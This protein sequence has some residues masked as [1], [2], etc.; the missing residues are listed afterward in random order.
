MVTFAQAWEMDR[1]TAPAWEQVVDWQPDAL[2]AY[3]DALG[4]IARDVAGTGGWPEEMHAELADVQEALA[5]G[6]TNVALEAHGF[7]ADLPAPVTAAHVAHA[8]RELAYEYTPPTLDDVRLAVAFGE[9]L[10]RNVLD[11]RTAQ[12]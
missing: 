8:A 6:A 11:S 1:G 5:N 10:F 12:G 2:I 4:A 7:D 3:A 9:A